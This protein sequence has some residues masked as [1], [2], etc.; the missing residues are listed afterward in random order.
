MFY[1]PREFRTFTRIFIAFC[2]FLLVVLGLAAVFPLY[3][4]YSQYIYQAG[5]QSTRV[6][7]IASSMMVLE[8]R[9]QAEHIDAIARIQ[10]ALP[11]LTK[12][13]NT[14]AI[15]TATDTRVLVQQS[16]PSFTLITTA[17][18]TVVSNPT[19]PVDP[20]EVDIVMKE[21]VEYRTDINL[22][23]QIL[24]Q[25]SNEYSNNLWLVETGDV[26]ILIGLGITYWIIMEKRMRHVIREEDAAKKV[27]VIT[28]KLPATNE[29][30]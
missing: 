12:E 13:Q 18:Q 6:E 10:T 19:K 4:N 21:R 22:V 17:A 5:L 26:G 7:V 14:L 28:N 23:V 30:A 20:A 1:P 9:P 11:A 2:I 27:T 25:H 15:S 3:A 24:V 16:Q 29:T 8:Y